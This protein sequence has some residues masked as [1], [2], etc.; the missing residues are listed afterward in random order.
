MKRELMTEIRD[1][2]LDT[3]SRVKLLLVTRYCIV[4]E[5]SALAA[6]PPAKVVAYDLV[7]GSVI[8]QKF[9]Q[10]K[11][12]P[13]NSHSIVIINGQ[14][15]HSFIHYYMYVKQMRILFCSCQHTAL[16]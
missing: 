15:Y 6:V 5:K 1:G 7:Y 11:L 4:E 2:N 3:P 16:R 10:G 14:L 12:V 13:E 8:G 9:L